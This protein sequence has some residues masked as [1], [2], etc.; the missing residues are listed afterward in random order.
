MG[1]GEFPAGYGL[2]GLDPLNPIS[3]SIFGNQPVPAIYFDLLTRRFLFDTNGRARGMHPIDQRVLLMLGVELGSIPSSPTVGNRF[4]KR[5]SR[6]A[7]AKMDAIA[8]DETKVTL[9]TLLDAGDIA[10]LSVATDGK[11]VPGRVVIAIGYVNLRDPK[12][13]LR[14]PGLNAQTLNLLS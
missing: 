14:N 11:T 4:R 6:V 8:L 2:A 7:A 3:P 10:L 12:T 9:K 5:L 1:A 13:N